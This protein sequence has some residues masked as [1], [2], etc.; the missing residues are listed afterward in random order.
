MRP[1]MEKIWMDLA[2]HLAK[3]STCG[4]KKVGT[5]ITSENLEQVFAV[6]YNGNAKKLPNICDSKEV[7][8]C[9]CLHSEVNALVKAGTRENKSLFVTL[10]PCKSCAKLMINANVKT[11]YFREYYRKIDGIKILLEGGIK[12][13]WINNEGLIIKVD[14]K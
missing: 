8:N 2:L 1:N 11:V 13:F 12:V 4:R 6:G 10:S 7:G 3:R 5:V 14:Q 9:G